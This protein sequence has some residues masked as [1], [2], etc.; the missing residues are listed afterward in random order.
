MEPIPPVSSTA[1]PQHGEPVTKTGSDGG[2]RSG[3][4]CASRA[5]SSGQTTLA[6]VHDKYTLTEQVIGV[7]PEISVVKRAVQRHSGK[8]VAVKTIAK[9]K[10]TERVRV[11]V[12][13]EVSVG[14]SLAPHPNIVPIYEVFESTRSVY[15][16]MEEADCDLCDLLEERGPLCEEDAA[17]LFIQIATGLDAMHRMGFV[18]RD[19]KPENILITNGAMAKICDFGLCK[20]FDPA[21]PD[22]ANPLK[23]VCGSRLYM[24]PEVLLG[25]P[26]SKACDVWGAAIV[27]CIMLTNAPPF[28]PALSP[29]LLVEAIA[30]YRYELAG[31]AWEDVSPQAIS[32]LKSILTPPEAR[33]SFATVV[34]HEWVKLA[35]SGM[36]NH[37]GSSANT[38]LGTLGSGDR[39]ASPPE[40]AAAPQN[41][42]PESPCT[43]AANPVAHPPSRPASD[44]HESPS[45]HHLPNR[46]LDPPPKADNP[47]SH[48][49]H[50]E[51][52][53]LAPHLHTPSWRA[54]GTPSPLSQGT[55]ASGGTPT[56]VGP[57]AAQNAGG[58]RKGS[59]AAPFPKNRG[60]P[61]APPAGEGG[62]WRER[63][64][65]S[66]KSKGKTMTTERT[67]ELAASRIA[68]MS[69]HRD[70][71]A[72]MEEGTG[73]RR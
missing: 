53:P 57:R 58:E 29:P 65:G 27:L 59:G 51:G 6:T 60:S 25:K 12:T 15:L 31:A 61:A 46:H 38:R 14:K 30:S 37:G 63:P 4:S 16:V 17:G 52:T 33:P 44:C 40:A 41:T 13:R 34:S 68:E 28:D 36:L 55:P 2:I 72:W 20:S 45:H 54:G 8:H 73:G 10:C 1:S 43:E 22:S 71:N 24:A 7:G 26:Y 39:A 9:D 42:T 66:R 21:L 70:V 64:R 11:V 5:S 49:H 62:G 35:R 47:P 67:L 69:G 32:I 19:V 23:T 50:G 56:A 18:H 48:R 3:S